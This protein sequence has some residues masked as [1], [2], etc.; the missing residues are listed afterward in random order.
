MHLTAEIC[1]IEN[2]CID[3]LFAHST[4]EFLSLFTEEEKDYCL[5]RKKGK[6]HLAARVA[7]K[8][9]VCTLLGSHAEIQWP[10]ILVK[11]MT[12]GVPYLLLT[13]RAADYAHALKITGWHLSLT[14][15]AQYAAALVIAERGHSEEE[16]PGYHF[17][18]MSYTCIEKKK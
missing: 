12:S 11:K 7:A 10:T 15:T 18:G 3:N 13:G 8:K 1:I 2:S 16:H 14:H 4:Q 17:A 6:I 5:A 9:A